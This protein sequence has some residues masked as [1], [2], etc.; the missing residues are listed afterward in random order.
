[1]KEKIGQM[2][3]IGIQGQSLSQEEKSFIVENNIGGVILFSRNYGSPEQLHELCGEIQSLSKLQK[4]KSPLFISID[5]EGGRVQ[6]FKTEPFTHWPPLAQAG[7][8]DNTSVT[9]MWAHLLS[10]DLKSFGVNLNFAPTLDILTNPNNTVIGDRA[11][12][13]D[14]RMVEKHASAWVRGALKAGILSCAKHFPGHGNTLLDSHLDLPRESVDLETLENRELVPF[15]KAFRSKVDFVMLAHIVFE[16]IDPD[17]PASLS[18]IFVDEILRKKLGFRGLIFTDDLD[19][20]ALKKN[21]TKEEI[22]VRAVEAGCEIL[23]YC[24]EPDSPQIALDS[25]IEAFAQ[26]RLHK[27]YLDQ[28]HLRI[29]LEKKQKLAGTHQLELKDA[30]IILQNSAKK[31]FAEDLKNGIAPDLTPFQPEKT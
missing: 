27:T 29:Q 30:M 17:W 22:A 20:G 28:V 26:E 7:K 25:L 19:M 12:S 5:Q 1:M 23:L 13:T 6:R 11:F 21:F 15:K 3:M 9:Y 2:L 4:D 16:K 14:F 31:K 8:I 10:Q 24:N 18:E